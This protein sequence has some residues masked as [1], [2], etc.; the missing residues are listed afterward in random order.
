MIPTSFQA[1]YPRLTQ[2]LVAMGMADA[3]ETVESRAAWV[4]VATELATLN[5]DDAPL[6]EVASSLLAGALEP[7]REL[8]RFSASAYRH[9]GVSDDVRVFMGR[10]WAAALSSWS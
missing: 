3:H 7:E 9:L 6:D 8:A 5:R 2:A 1:Q 10:L 4:D